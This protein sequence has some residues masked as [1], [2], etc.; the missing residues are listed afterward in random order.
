MCGLK[1]TR[2]RRGHG[3][4]HRGLHR[5]GVGDGQEGREEGDK[6]GEGEHVGGEGKREEGVGVDVGRK[7]RKKSASIL[8]CG[9]GSAP[10]GAL[11]MPAAI[12]GLF[13]ST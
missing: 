11:V 8:T 5:R 9:S 7:K 13:R 6:A 1:L 3:G 4:V 12:V 2:G 10:S